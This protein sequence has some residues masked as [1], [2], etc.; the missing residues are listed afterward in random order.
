MKPAAPLSQ[1]SAAYEIAASADFAE[2]AGPAVS[3]VTPNRLNARCFHEFT[4]VF[5]AAAIATVLLARADA[6]MALAR[7]C[8]TGAGWR[9]QHWALGS[10][11]YELGKTWMQPAF[12]LSVGGLVYALTSLKITARR[13]YR[14]AA[15]FLPLFLAIEPGL[16]VNAGFKDHWAR[17][18]PCQLT[19]FGGV[20][21]FQQPWQPGDPYESIPGTKKPSFPCGHAAMG[22]FMIA[23][24]FILRRKNHRTA[25][26]WLA[27][28]LAF[29]ALIGASRISQGGH[30]LSDIVWS[31]TLVYLTGLILARLMKLDE[32]TG[33]VPQVSAGRAMPVRRKQ[34]G[35]F[36]A[37]LR[38]SVGL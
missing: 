28:G 18:R 9:G 7:F 14:R 1:R 12:L 16:V 34:A 15:L 24:W 10:S 25:S 8:H 26:L 36:V 37:A 4:L 27:G 21:T 13:Q 3:A 29:G 11:L 19:E 20:F 22:F 6:D 32:T 38:G 30:F 35:V 17:P 23:P 5:L 2:R 33:E 31:G